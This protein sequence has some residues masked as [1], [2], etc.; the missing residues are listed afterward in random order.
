MINTIPEDINIFS[1][2]TLNETKIYKTTSKKSLN[3][4]YHNYINIQVNAANVIKKFLKYSHQLFTIYKSMDANLLYK[5]N[6]ETKFFKNFKFMSVNLLYMDE[7]NVEYANSFIKGLDCNYKL[8]L[9]N[10]YIDVDLTKKYSKYDLNRI[11]S[12]M[13]FPDIFYVGF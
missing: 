4:V 1:F 12:I 2:L 7:Y 13:N 10:K 3:H 6:R 5:I 9:I 11:L 8:G